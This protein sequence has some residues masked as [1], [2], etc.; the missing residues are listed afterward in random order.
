MRQTVGEEIIKIHKASDVV[1]FRESPS[2]S[3][4]R[5]RLGGA[6]NVG[7]CGSSSPRYLIRS[8]SDNALESPASSSPGPSL[9]SLE[10]TNTSNRQADTHSLRRQT[11]RLSPSGRL[12]RTPARP[13]SPSPVQHGKRRLYSA[14]PGGR[15]SLPALTHR[16]APERSACIVGRGSK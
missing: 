7:V 10:N 6:N 15:S 5:R 3:S 8:A 11:R 13:I 16:R 9:H 12:Q 2:Y 1:P 4:K 14:V